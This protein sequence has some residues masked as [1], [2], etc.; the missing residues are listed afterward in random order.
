MV[1]GQVYDNLGLADEAVEIQEEALQIRRGLF[2]NTHPDVAKSLESLARIHSGARELHTA[3]PLYEEALRIRRSSGGDPVA[4]AEPLQGIARLLR[5]LGKPDS[6]EV[7]IRE[8]VGIRKSLQGE[9]HFQTV[10]ALM[11]LAFVLRGKGQLDSAQV[12]YEKAIPILETHGDSGA[13]LLPPTLNNLAYL[14][15]TRGEFAEAERVYRRAVTLE[16]QEG[17]VPNFLLLMNNLASVLD[18]QGK[19]EETEEA[20]QEVIR[21]SEEHWPAGHWRVG[22]AYGGMGAFKMFSGATSAAEP[23]LRRAHLIT[24]E[25]LGEDNPRVA[26][27]RTQLGACLGSLGKF[28]EAESHLLHAFQWLR[29]NNGI[30]SPYTQPTIT[31]LIALYESWDRPEVAEEFRQMIR[32]E[33]T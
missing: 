4:Q 32:R 23:Y 13:S 9:D 18:L 3:L 33:G 22:S 16:R 29:E 14:L 25:A 28:A 15:R 6:A 24:K 10:S 1:L 30:E 12:L 2:G 8:A 11:D 5:D 27:T 20:L 31:H 21:I 26:Y 19:G 7:L 17:T